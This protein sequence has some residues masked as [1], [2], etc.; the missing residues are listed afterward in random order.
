[1]RN[2]I[3]YLHK[4][5]KSR[6]IVLGFLS[7]V[8]LGIVEHLVGP[9][10]FFSMFYFIPIFLVTWFT[11][12]KIGIILSI[13]SAGAWLLANYISYALGRTSLHPVIVCWNTG[14]SLITFL[15]TTFILSSVK[16]A[17]EQ[18]KKLARLDPLTGIANRRSFVELMGAE[19]HRAW[20][21]QRPFTIVHFDLD[22][23]KTVNDRFGHSTGDTLLCLVGRIIQENIRATDTIARL[24]GDEFAILL[25]ETGPESARVVIQKVQ[26]LNLQ[27]M[28]R[29]GWPVTLSMGVVTFISPPATV[30][31]MLRFSD[32]LMYEAKNDGKNAIKYEVYE[33]GQKRGPSGQQL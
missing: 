3:F 6:L 22:N 12:R 16:S 21:Y 30:D 23:F 19:M 10:C 1:M 20:R 26:E 28:K 9:G 27:V 17:L 2:L 18:E 15:L 5:P 4:Q 8:L 25:P 32:A 33:T 31:E 14:I 24:G 11:E 13:A 29:N 7:L